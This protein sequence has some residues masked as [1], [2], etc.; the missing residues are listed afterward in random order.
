M[1]LDDFRYRLGNDEE[2]GFPFPEEEEIR[3]DY[4]D[5]EQEEEED[6]EEE[7]KP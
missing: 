3:E 6:L 4:L 5:R 1:A 7:T 2:E